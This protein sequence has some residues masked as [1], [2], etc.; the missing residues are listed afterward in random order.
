MKPVTAKLRF[1]PPEQ[2]GRRT[3]PTGPHYST[4]A[5]FACV[6]G[7]LAAEAW[8]LLVTFRDTISEE[9]VVTADIAFLAPGAPRELLKQGACFT[10]L[11][12]ARPVCS[13]EI[14][15]SNAAE[16][17]ERTRAQAFRWMQVELK[18]IIDRWGQDTQVNEPDVAWSAIKRMGIEPEAA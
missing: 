2:G 16:E 3:R 13:G 8:S 6:P 18:A 7:A 10:L 14:I 1:L 5:D 17:I 4:V 11:E 12:G 15:S 9:G